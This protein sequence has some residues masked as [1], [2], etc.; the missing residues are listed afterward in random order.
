MELKIDYFKP[1]GKWYN[2]A[3]T[4]VDCTSTYD[5][6]YLAIQVLLSRLAVGEYPGLSAA[7]YDFNVLITDPEGL[8]HMFTADFLAGFRACHKLRF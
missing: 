6:F 4:N 7:G 5:G 8:Q 3:T 2:S 1:S